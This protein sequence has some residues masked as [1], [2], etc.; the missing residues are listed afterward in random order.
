MI[1]VVSPHLD[2]AV[3]SCGGLLALARRRGEPSTVVT[4][5]TKGRD[6]DR[7]RD[8][9]RDALAVLG[10]RAVHVG[11]LD[12][13]ERLG[14]ART[15]TALVEEARVDPADCAVV[16]AAIETALPSPS[17]VSVYV[18][19]GVGGHVDHVTVHAAL[20]DRDDVVF[21]EDRPYALV[22]GAIHARLVEAR[23]ALTAPDGI[24][25]ASAAALGEPARALPHLDAFLGSEPVARARSLAWL[26]SHHGDP[27]PDL[28]LAPR[29]ARVRRHP[30]D[31]EAVTLAARAASAY[32]S[33]GRLLP[34][35]L[36]SFERTFDPVARVV[37]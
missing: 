4:V 37:R 25:K 9:D 5:F 20:R 27:R 30:I 18:P 26:E 13:P 31:N 2:D 6:H 14:L 24:A 3:L 7:R 29:E 16:R 28:A 33:Q 11:L 21:Y 22:P 36:P 15:H 35:N 19:L 1:V 8:E 32:A 10:A 23:I 17:P 34:A 12:A